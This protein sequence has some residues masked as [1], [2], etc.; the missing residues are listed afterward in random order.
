MFDC[1]VPS[2]KKKNKRSR[3][4][5]QGKETL[6]FNIIDFHNSQMLALNRLIMKLGRIYLK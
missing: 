1:H 6:P 5:Y 3:L 2:Q 4:F